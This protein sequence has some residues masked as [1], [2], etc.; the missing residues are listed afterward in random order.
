MTEIQAAIGIEQ[1]KKL[2]KIIYQKQE[3]ATKLINGLKNLKGIKLPIIKKGCTH[4][5][6]NFPIQIDRS[7][8]KVSRDKIFKNLKLEGVPV[9]NAYPSI[10]LLPLFQK[11][12]A[13]EICTSH[14][15]KIKNIE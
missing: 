12:I 1:L 10:H 13:F 7:V 5:F 11:K 9:S 14:G 2:D 8:I 6:Y 4:A 3:T 15:R